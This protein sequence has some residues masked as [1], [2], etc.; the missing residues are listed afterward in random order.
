MKLNTK[1]R[2]GLRTVIEIAMSDNP[3]G[4]LQKDIAE[5]QK[6]SVKYLDSIV[7]SLKIKGIVVNSK[8]RGGGYRLT[9]AA[10][11]ISMLDIYTAFEP[12]TV[13]ECI[14]NKDFC[15]QACDCVSR[16]YWVEFRNNFIEMLSKKSLAQIILENNKTNNYKN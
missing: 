8:G 11:E 3:E 6:I 9:R 16:D 14:E 13:V 1:I 7:S 2:Y 15:D 5:K 4:V 12:L 10:E